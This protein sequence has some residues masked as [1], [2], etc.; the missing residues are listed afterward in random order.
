[1]ASASIFAEYPIEKHPDLNGSLICLD[2][3]KRSY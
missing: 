3:K 2:P 1:M